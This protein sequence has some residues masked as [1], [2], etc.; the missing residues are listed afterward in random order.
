MNYIILDLEATCWKT[1]PPNH[2]N[3]T[4]EIGAVAIDEN[5][6]ILGEFNE[7]IKPLVHPVLSDFCKELTSIN[8]EMIDKADTYPIVLERFQEWIQSFGE[9]YYLCSWGFYD[10]NQFK[11]DCELH[12]LP[13]DWLKQHMSI[14]HQHGKVRGLKRNMGMKGALKFEGFELDGTHHRGI[15][16]ARNIAKIFLKCFDKWKF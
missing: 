6:N 3:E 1:R 11:L 2:K 13:T 7:M 5:K 10:K 8:Q 4:I 16:D 9:E 15:D 12:G 14:K